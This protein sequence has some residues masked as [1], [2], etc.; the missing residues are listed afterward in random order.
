MEVRVA[1]PPPPLAGSAGAPVLRVGLIV[2]RHRQSAVARN[3]VKRRLRE[4]VRRELLPAGVAAD[5]VLRV[6]PGAYAVTFDGLR[7]DVL[8]A[9]RGV[10]EW[11]A[12]QLRR[13]SSPPDA[14]AEEG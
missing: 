2:P 14:A 10:A 5:V 3:R 13:Q 9:R 11:Y 8:R 7:R 4:L 1:T 6:R 12:E